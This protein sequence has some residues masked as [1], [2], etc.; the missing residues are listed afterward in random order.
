MHFQV[1]EV[2]Q[3]RGISNHAQLVIPPRYSAIFQVDKVAQLR[4]YLT[5]Q[6]VRSR[7]TDFQTGKIAQ[8]RSGIS[9]VQLVIAEVA[10]QHLSG[11]RGCPTP[12]I[13]RSHSTGCRMEDQPSSQVGKVAQLRRYLSAQLVTARM[14]STDRVLRL[15]RLPNSGDI[16]PL[17]WLP[18]E[19][20][21]GDAAVTVSG[22][23]EPLAN[24]RVPQPVI[25]AFSNSEPLDRW[26]HRGQSAFPGQLCSGRTGDQIPRSELSISNWPNKLLGTHPIN[27][28]ATAVRLA[29]SPNSGGISPV[30][31]SL[32][33]IPSRLARLPNS[34]GI[35]PIN[36]LGVSRNRLAGCPA[37]TVSLANRLASQALPG[38]R[39][40]PA[41]SLKSTG[42]S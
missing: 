42:C 4:R 23:A 38:W 39:V 1:G 33:T 34:G 19:A 12:A 22:D 32:R 16:S 35:S 24:R 13:S 21:F 36:W 14:Q 30:L 26:R 41:V 15:A 3:L 2:T 40:T 6:L 31:F 29:R 27:A 7:G 20:Q 9:A 37:P 28:L 18:V 17:N 5:P 11:W 10:V 8:L 25:V